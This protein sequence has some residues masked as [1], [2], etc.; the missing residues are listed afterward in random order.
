MLL[1]VDFLNEQGNL[2]FANTPD[3]IKANLKA[4]PSF[5]KDVHQQHKQGK[6]FALMNIVGR[7]M[8]IYQDQPT[9]STSQIMYFLDFRYDLE[10]VIVGMFSAPLAKAI[11]NAQPQFDK[12]YREINNL[13]ELT[14]AEPYE[15][16]ISPGIF[17]C[18]VDDRV[19]MKANTLGVLPILEAK[20]E[21]S[22]TKVCFADETEGEGESAIR[23]LYA[24]LRFHGATTR[25]DELDEGYVYLKLR[26]L[27]NNIELLDSFFDK[28]LNSGVSFDRGAILQR[29]TK[30]RLN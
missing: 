22:G 30:H 7:W 17:A 19:I 13:V 28:V 27:E 10:S 21:D 12:E 6:A 23:N 26:D 2:G 8:V 29:F 20:K 11:L 1:N 16:M 15:V 4:L 25:Q 14:L 24:L 3:K 18:N 5:E 9:S